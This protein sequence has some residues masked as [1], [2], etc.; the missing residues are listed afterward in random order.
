MER[1][2]TER[3]VDQLIKRRDEIAMTL[4]HLGKERAEVERNTEWVSRDAYERRT[5]FLSSIRS[6]Y[7]SEIDEIQKALTGAETSDHGFCAACGELIEKRL[8]TVTA[9][10]EFCPACWP[11]HNHEAEL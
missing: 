1:I 11:C 6:W 7:V 5:R 9:G 3:H 4:R 10:S 2:R 8:L